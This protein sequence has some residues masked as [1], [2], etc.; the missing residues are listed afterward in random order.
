ME[1][2]FFD[3]AYVNPF[4]AV[5][6][7]AGDLDFD[8]GLADVNLSRAGYFQDALQI[9]I[10]NAAADEDRDAASRRFDE[11]GEC[12]ERGFGFWFAARCEDAICAGKNHGFQRLMEIGSHVEGAMEGDRKG[13]RDFHQLAR[14]RLIYMSV[15][16][17]YSQ[18]DSIGVEVFCYGD[19]ALHNVNFFRRVAE[20]SAARANHDVQRDG[21]LFAGHSDQARAGR[22]STGEQIAAQ[23]DAICAAALRGK[24]GFDGVNANF[25]NRLFR[26]G[27]TAIARV[28]YVSHSPPHD[29]RLLRGI[30]VGYWQLTAG[31]WRAGQHCQRTSGPAASRRKRG[32]KVTF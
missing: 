29:R 2:G 12:I 17:Q 28:N 32:I 1:F 24:S 15:A 27:R 13:T 4:V 6:D 30:S 23:L 19:V 18:D 16:V 7:S 8:T 31:L 9:V 26:H 5:P 3:C 20:I 14:A 21:D 11:G 25:E 22:D 10:A